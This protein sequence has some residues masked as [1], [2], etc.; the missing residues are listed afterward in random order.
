MAT[1]STLLMDSGSSIK[2]K[3]VI[4]YQLKW[5]TNIKNMKADS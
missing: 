1:F 2:G 4:G 5:K 3:I